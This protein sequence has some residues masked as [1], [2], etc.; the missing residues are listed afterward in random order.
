MK[1]RASSVSSSATSSPADV[2]PK[3]PERNP[4]SLSGFSGFI[5]SPSPP[6]TYGINQNKSSNS[7]GKVQSSISKLN[8]MFNKAASPTPDLKPTSPKKADS[9]SPTP[10]EAKLTNIEEKAPILIANLVL[11]LIATKQMQP[12]LARR[13][14]IL[15]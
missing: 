15:M 5:T 7:T 12:L 2:A 8:N 13:W 11:P 4:S 10:I 1:N 6:A 14:I 9:K 3:T